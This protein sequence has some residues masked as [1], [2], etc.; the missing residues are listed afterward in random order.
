MDGTALILGVAALVIGGGG[1]SGWLVSR[2]QSRKVL[3]EA[4]QVGISADVAEAKLRPEIDSIAVASLSKATITLSTENDRLHRRLDAASD[5]I[6]RQARTIGE[7]A[8]TIDKQSDTIAEYRQQVA[9]LTAQVAEL[10]VALDR[11]KDELRNLE[12]QTT[13]EAPPS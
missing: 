7:Q 11:I 3:N 10:Q 2:A 8:L 1:F 5:T 13:Q 4:R 12:I 6:E 9:K